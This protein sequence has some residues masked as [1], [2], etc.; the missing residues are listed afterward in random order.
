MEKYN[1]IS[2]LKRGKKKKE[3]K[4]SNGNDQTGKLIKEILRR[5][6]GKSLKMQTR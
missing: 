2:K 5:K 3:E 6:E 4:V 1:K